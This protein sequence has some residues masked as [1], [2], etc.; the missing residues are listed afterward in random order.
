[1]RSDVTQDVPLF[2]YSVIEAILADGTHP[3]IDG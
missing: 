3:L 2:A 1:M